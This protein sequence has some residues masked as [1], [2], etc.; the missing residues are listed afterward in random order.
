LFGQMKEQLGNRVR[1]EK[2][3]LYE[4]DNLWVD[5]FAEGVQ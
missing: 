3:R 4:N 2:M 1:L 5:Q